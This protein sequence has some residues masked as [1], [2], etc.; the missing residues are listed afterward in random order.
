MIVPIFVPY[1]TSEDYYYE[2]LTV[3]EKKKYLRDKA[4]LQEEAWNN[5]WNG[6]KYFKYLDKAITEDLHGN[7]ELAKKYGK[8]SD[9]WFWILT[10]VRTIFSFLVF[11]LPLIGVFA[12]SF[13]L[14]EYIEFSK[15]FG[16]QF[17]QQLYM[18][19]LKLC[20]V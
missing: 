18:Q 11:G 19:F 3:E 8:L 9:F 16:L 20:L 5:M 14:L 12:L 15:V 6:T 2:S 1:K 17:L 7:N 10:V 4:E 13:Y